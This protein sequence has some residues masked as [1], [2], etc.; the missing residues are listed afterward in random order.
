MNCGLWIYISYYFGDVVCMCVFC[1]LLLT[2]LDAENEINLHKLGMGQYKT[3][4]KVYE[5]NF[6]AAFYVPICLSPDT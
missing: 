4:L 6:V 5:C 1:Y 2:N 3:C